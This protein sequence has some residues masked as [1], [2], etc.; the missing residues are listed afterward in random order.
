[1]TRRRRGERGAETLEFVACA[2]LLVVVLAGVSKV[3]ALA[4][5]Q[6]EAENDVRAVAREAVVCDQTTRPSL[7]A[8]DPDAHA[9]GGVATVIPLAPGRILAR[10][11]IP[12][13]GPLGALG[14]HPHAELA[15]SLEPGCP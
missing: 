7:D 15:M 13:G 11:D 3:M 6:A 14:F 2:A 1:M 4:R 10:V 9:R 8:L 12:A 5:L